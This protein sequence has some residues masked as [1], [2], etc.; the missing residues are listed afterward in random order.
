M[1]KWVAP[2]PLGAAYNTEPTSMETKINITKDK[3]TQDRA[4]SFLTLLYLKIAETNP[5][6][7]TE[8]GNFQAIEGKSW[9]APSFLGGKLYV[10]NLTE[11]ACYK[12]K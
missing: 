9:T 8:K 2:L 6:A 7:Y 11:M 4:Y 10:R 3:I 5:D 1:P 12:M